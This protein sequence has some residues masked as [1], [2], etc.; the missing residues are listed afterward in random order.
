MQ[1]AD[2]KLK[3]RIVVVHALNS[4]LSYGKRMNNQ[5]QS[6]SGL[7]LVRSSCKRAYIYAVV[8]EQ[9]VVI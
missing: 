2:L 1:A 9:F 4:V 3:W 5:L 8:V 6:V 7:E